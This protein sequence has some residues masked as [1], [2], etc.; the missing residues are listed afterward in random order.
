MSTLTIQRDT[1]WADKFRKYRILVDG[2]EVGQLGER[3]MLRHEISE[4]PH[5]I[6]AKIDW[7][8]GRPL[9]F[10]AKSKEQFFLVRSAL[11]GWRLL[12]VPFYLFFNRYGYLKID[13]IFP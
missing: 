8:G 7:C 10:E 2:V 9:Q 6:E 12:I 4:G 5:A 11:R 1:G 3:E 13:Q